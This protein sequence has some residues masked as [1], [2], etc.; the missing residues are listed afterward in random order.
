MRHPRT[1][2]NG[3]RQGSLDRPA[4]MNSG[5]YA[6]VRYARQLCPL[7][8]RERLPVVLKDGDIPLVSSLLF[9]G[10]PSA[11]VRVVSTV[12]VN[13]VDGVRGGGRCAHVKKERLETFAPPFAHLNS[14]SPVERVVG[15]AEAI[16]TPE[17]QPPSVVFLRGI[18][19]VGVVALPMLEVLDAGH[20]PVQAPARLSVTRSEFVCPNGAISATRA[21]AHPRN[22]RPTRVGVRDICTP[23][24]NKQATEY[25]TRKINESWHFFTLKWLTV[26][27]AW[28]AAVNSFS[29]ATLAKHLHFSRGFA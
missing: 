25:L 7:H 3:R 17:H 18:P 19:A 13:P 11:V 21:A 29:G 9:C 23:A 5:V 1:A 14:P 20:F 27:G 24:N 4:A 26:M 6:L 8:W 16:A 22:R 2:L 28:Q 10:G 15:A 12:G